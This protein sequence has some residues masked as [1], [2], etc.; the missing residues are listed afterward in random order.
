[1]A[2]SVTIKKDNE[3]LYPKTV[4]SLV[5]NRFTGESVEQDLNNKLESSDL[6][7]VNGA[8]LIGSGN[9]DISLSYNDLTS[10]EKAELAQ[11]ATLA[12]QR[13]EL[14]LATIQNTL[15]SLDLQSPDDTV[16]ALAAQVASINLDI[17]DN[18]KG[19]YTGGNS[20]T[21]TLQLITLPGQG[22][23]NYSFSQ[24]NPTIAKTNGYTTVYCQINNGDNITIEASGFNTLLSGY[25]SSTPASGSQV[26]S[27]VSGT[28]TFIASSDCYLV[29]TYDTVTSLNVYTG[30]TQNVTRTKLTGTKAGVFSIDDETS[31][32][33]SA[34]T[35]NC[36]YWPVQANSAIIFSPDSYENS[37]TAASVKFGF[38]QQIPEVDVGVTSYQGSTSVLINDTRGL[39]A[40][41]NGYFVFCAA[42]SRVTAA[43]QVSVYEVTSSQ[44]VQGTMS[45]VPMTVNSDNLIFK[46]AQYTYTYYWPVQEGSTINVIIN[47]ALKAT[48]QINY[49]FSQSLPAMG[50][51]AATYEGPISVSN[52]QYLLT[53]QAPM[54]GYYY[55]LIANTWIDSINQICLAEGV[56]RT[57]LLL[58]P[59]SD[60][61]GYTFTQASPTIASDNNSIL[62]YGYVRSG[63]LVNVTSSGTSGHYALG[64]CSSYPGPNVAVSGVYEQNSA[65][66][67]TQSITAPVSG[68]IVVTH[69]T[70][71]WTDS[72]TQTANGGVVPT[73][74]ELDSRV[75]VI[76]E[77]PL[78]SYSI[79]EKVELDAGKLGTIGGIIATSQL[80]NMLNNFC[81]LGF[82]RMSD[83]EFTSITATE[84]Y[85][86]ACFDKD[87]EHLG[88]VTTNTLISGTEYIRIGIDGASSH[89]YSKTSVTVNA[90][91]HA[92]TLEYVKDSAELNTFKFYS[93]ELTDPSVKDSSSSTYDGP[94]PNRD[95]N[96]GWIV[97]PTNYN[98]TGQP[99]PLIIFAHGTGGYTFS[100]FSSDDKLYK[101]LVIQLSR[102]GYAIMD[103][104]SLGYYGNQAVANASVPYKDINCTT[105]ISLACYVQGVNYVKRRWNL[106]D[107]L[108]VMGKSAG[109]KFVGILPHL[110]PIKAAAGLAPS[111]ETLVDL[112]IQG[113]SGCVNYALS[114]MGY[115]N[116]NVSSQLNTA[117]S[118]SY[119][120]ANW[121]NLIGYDA[122]IMK[123]TGLNYQ[124]WLTAIVECDPK[125][126]STYE[127]ATLQTMIDGAQ[128]FF[129]CPIKIWQ[130]QDDV[131]VP[132]KVS[133]WFVQMIRQAGCIAEMR[134]MPSGTGA[135]HSVDTDENAVTTTYITKFGETI[136]GMPIAYAELVDWFDKWL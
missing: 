133:S 11:D 87:F 18:I 80:S 59:V 118:R 57:N 17:D 53:V 52:S 81:Q 47:H 72:A 20:Q 105:P 12:A 110:L 95:Y 35:T 127:S 60:S 63:T 74:A 135:H 48:S 10:E 136:T 68:Y 102:C 77:T 67:V 37:G 85:R 84:P 34:T 79:S 130:A 55:L 124:Q 49:G 107:D 21:S 125:T 54:T 1:M 24:A 69:S 46:D 122:F 86:I 42:T 28:R 76:E 3:I 2:K 26:T 108:F 75:S 71:G 30:S 13:A 120:L 123:T 83:Q 44:I 45:S 70:S 33:K 7:T 16:A 65:T 78:Y 90:Q 50:V 64:F 38:T 25:C 51:Y 103:V 32:I 61:V 119:V 43:T 109:G 29:I 116:P 121:Q 31:K 113:T 23:T 73:L 22:D 39:V 129:P 14:A 92:P 131:N 111:T 101:A 41:F 99:V 128:C 98:R 56:G 36:F 94:N 82:T 66:S 91:Y 89:N 62:K 134:T 9:I 40:P 97:L 104:S 58:N 100:S 115:V 112:R 15:Q 96:N 126:P 88:D 93:Y 19:Q 27:I 117:A 8:S 5:Y 6:K 132:Y 114:T 4:S 106:S